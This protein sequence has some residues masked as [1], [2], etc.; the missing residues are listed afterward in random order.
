LHFPER[1]APIIHNHAEGIFGR[2][3]YAFFVHSNFNSN[4]IVPNVTGTNPKLAGKTLHEIG[5]KQPVS[6]QTYGGFVG[7][8]AKGSWIDA[9]DLNYFTT[10]GAGLG[11]ELVRFNFTAFAASG[12]GLFTIHS[13]TF[14]LIDGYMN[15]T[16]DGNSIIG[17]FCNNG[18][19]N[20]VNE[21][22]SFEGVAVVRGGNC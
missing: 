10:F 14:V 19:L 13:S 21:N 7:N 1:L 18:A 6:L 2:S 8:Y 3:P 11:H 9:L 16:T 12:M 20:I 5:Y 17:I 4:F 15:A 22:T